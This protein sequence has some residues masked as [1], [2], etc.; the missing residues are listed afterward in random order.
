MGLRTERTDDILWAF[1]TPEG[2]RPPLLTR[3]VMADLRR[4]AEEARQVPPR[5]LVFAAESGG[6]FQAGADVSAMEEVDA[7]QEA[8]EASREGQLLFQEF[9][10]LSFPVIAAIEGRCLGGG[11]ELAL[12][13]DTRIAA[14][15]ESWLAFPEVHIGILPGWGGTQRLPRLIGQRRSLDMILTGQAVDAEKALQ[16]GLVDRVV[17]RERLH[18][19]AADLVEEIRSGRFRPPAR[20]M[21]FRPL[22]LLMEGTGLGRRAFRNR[23]R[24]A[25]R[26]RTGGHY[27][28]P[29]RVIEAVG[30]AA[31]GTPLQEGLEEEARRLADLVSGEVH[32]H[33]LALLR[34]RQALR[35]PRGDREGERRDRAEGLEVPA[36]VSER[37]GKLMAPPLKAGGSTVPGGDVPAMEVSG[38][39][40][41]LRRLPCARPPLLAEVT[42]FPAA[43]APDPFEDA[44]RHLLASA[45]LLGVFCYLAEP[46]PGLALAASFLRE[47]ERL[48]AEGWSR[49]RIDGVLTGWGMH[50]GPFGLLRRLGPAWKE[51]LDTLPYR[52]LPERSPEA[53]PSPDAE[54]AEER[55]V[56]EVVS[57]MALEMSR[58]WDLV[59]EPVEEGWLLLDVF[60]LGAPPFRG[61][62]LGAARSLG[63]ERTASRLQAVS[64]RWGLLYRPDPLI[65]R[66][67]L[68][69]RG[70][71]SLDEVIEEEMRGSPPGRDGDVDREDETT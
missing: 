71:P 24:K 33:L 1:F 40:G 21:G 18:A 23:Y 31:D 16:W 39:A 13:C 51:R 9:A 28:A 34:A 17:S 3:G 55:L 7:W 59:A 15:E 64:E 8:Y 26:K 42:W 25:V 19:E 37:F 45:D 47:G 35:R 30:I 32:R 38:G 66:G 27:P 67:L 14:A 57:V 49:E 11:V 50:A 56:E 44:A 36:D 63:E 61:G 52:R 58:L 5:G 48:V 53:F 10:D 60:M 62:L 2:R 46:S 20:R 68:R 54:E 4:L 43:G 6:D 70:G 41:L 12:A 29:S 65:E 22:Q 69:P